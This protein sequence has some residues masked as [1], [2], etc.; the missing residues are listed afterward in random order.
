MRILP[1]RAAGLD[2]AVEVLGGTC[3]LHT[4]AMRPCVAPMAAVAAGTRF[5]TPVRRLI[6]S[7]TGIDFALS[8]DPA[9]LLA[10]QLERPALLASALQ[11]ASVEADLVLL[12]A[13]DEQLAASA[14]ACCRLPVTGPLLEADGSLAPE[15]LAVLFTSGAIGNP[16]P[17][18]PGPRLAA[19]PCPELASSLPPGHTEL[20]EVAMHSE[21]HTA[22]SAMLLPV[23]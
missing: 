18:L 16:Q 9:G 10:T 12:A 23:P 13:R 14:A 7:V 11:L 19:S 2:A 6:S 17:F 5:G 21:A 20:T 8:G 1:R 22:P 4:P 15:V 3:A